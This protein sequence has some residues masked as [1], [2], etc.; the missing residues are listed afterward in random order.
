M[1]SESRDPV[2]DVWRGPVIRGVAGALVQTSPF[3]LEMHTGW[4][5][6]TGFIH[7]HRCYNLISADLLFYWGE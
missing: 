3:P 2:V 4:E 5:L 6:V 7:S 1:L